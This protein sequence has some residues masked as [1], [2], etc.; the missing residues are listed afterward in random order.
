MH[1]LR[2]P[3]WFFWHWSCTVRNATA[4]T[5]FTHVQNICCPDRCFIDVNCSVNISSSPLRC[6][7]YI[8]FELSAN[9]YSH[10]KNANRNWFLRSRKCFSRTQ[11]N[12]LKRKQ[13]FNQSSLWYLII[14]GKWK[15]EQQ[16]K[17]WS[18]EF[19]VGSRKMENKDKEWWKVKSI[20]YV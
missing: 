15:S 14:I 17:F 13:D 2:K 11:K 16:Q 5:F 7:V 12:A 8:G 6:L 10:G 19:C 3:H 20:Q 4:H 1:I 18:G 9:S